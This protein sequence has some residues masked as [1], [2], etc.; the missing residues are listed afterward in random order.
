MDSK[1]ATILRSHVAYLAQG[2]MQLIQQLNADNIHAAMPR[3]LQLASHLDIT[4]LL[5][6]HESFLIIIGIMN[7]IKPRSYDWYI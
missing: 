2:G 4:V 1:P 6:E 5:S 3:Q 7:R